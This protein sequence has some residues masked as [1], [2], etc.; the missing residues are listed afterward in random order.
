MD[1]YKNL[2]YFV[3]TLMV[4][5]LILIYKFLGN[6]YLRKRAEQELREKNEEVTAIYEEIAASDEELKS[7]MQLL[8]EKQEEL[9]RSEQRYRIVMESTMDIIWEGDLINNKRLFSGKLYDVLGYKAYEME[10][11]D[12]WFN[13]VHPEDIGWVKRG[14]KQQ[15]EGK[16]EVESFEYRVKCKDG[17]YKWVLSN[18]KCEFD[19][20]G[21]AIAVFGA[22]TDISELKEQRQRINKLAYYDSVTGLPN[23]VMLR[24]MVEEEI[25]EFDKSGNKF[26]LFFIDLD[27]FKFVNDTYG[28]LVGDKLLL[29]VAKRLIE[30]QTENMTTFRLGG[31]EFN[32][33]LKN[34]E[35]KEEVEMYSKAVLKALAEPIFIDGNMFRVTHSG[36]IVLYPE[37]GLDFDELLKKAD[38]AMY[39]SKESGKSTY[40]FYH[41]SMGNTAVEKFKM[42]S[43]LYRAIENNEFML[44]Y[45]PIIDVDQGGIKGFEALIRWN[46]PEKGIVFPDKFISVAE[47]NGTIIEI[48][49]WVIINACKYAKSIYD[50]GYTNFY[51][52]VNVSTLQLIQRDFTDFIFETLE[53][54]G[55]SPELLLLEITESVLMESM[56]LV[57]EKL[58]KLK[59]NNI[60][61]ALDDFGCGYSSLKYLKM[62]P[63]NT[64]KID[65]SFIDDIKSED[66]VKG[67]AR[68]II[69]LAK[70]LGLSVIGEGVETNEQLSYLKK[71]GCDRFQGYLISK[72]VP[73]IEASSLL[74][75][76]VPSTSAAFMG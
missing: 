29:E 52:S 51:V 5:L 70:Q 25:S 68:S 74:M 12:A 37:N 40:T 10:A 23:R 43:D 32:I 50:I 48:G 62:L 7:N 64:V 61:I 45:Q 15:V 14:I 1:M 54:I 38:T 11:L 65:K 56:D 58:K 2:T 31:D 34:I 3:C 36:G 49:K 26:T 72:P 33:L 47:E 21:A 20:N 19:E 24:E 6:I 44:Y 75:Q 27:D 16:I 42:Q 22:F 8:M 4:F 28:H 53:N 66:D 17:T 73:E 55:L 59:D 46:H 35:N 39:K 30:I 67:M 13:I 9:L 76:G 71:H 18:T 57:I 69:L 41:N 63:I 60:K